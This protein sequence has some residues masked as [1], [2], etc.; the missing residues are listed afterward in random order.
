[1][2]NSKIIFGDDVLIDLTEDTVTPS[3]LHKGVTAHAASG[4][5]IEGEFT[6]EEELENQKSLIDQIHAALEGK[7]VGCD[8]TLLDDLMAR[9]ITVLDT[10]RLT[11][12]G[13]YALANWASLESVNLPSVTSLQGR[14]TFY[15]CDNLKSVRMENVTYLG[16]NTFVQCKKLESVYFPEVDRFE[17]T[18]FAQCASLD[19][20]E[21][22]KL[23]IMMPGVFI[24]CTNLKRADFLA[25]LR[26]DQ[27]DFMGCTSLET[28][29]LRRSQVVL[30]VNTN[31]F[32]DS[33][34]SNGTGFVY[35]P[36][37]LVESYKT[38][39]NWSNF[40]SQI[41]AI[42]DYPEICS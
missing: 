8:D 40:A 22:P 30:L 20:V 28:L 7:A 24:N 14:Y 18:V 27:T 13:E 19:N 29:I 10:D 26:I 23:T 37:E 1:M 42:E 12:L 11:V 2:G 33:G 3:T 6:L 17:A 31:A 38:A 5:E 4:D 35:V 32:D 25:L 16:R 15:K 34:L 21:F 36:K 41:R 39:S 9:T